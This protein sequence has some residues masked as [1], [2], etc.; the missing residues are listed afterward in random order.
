MKSYAKK[1]LPAYE[2]GE[3][4]KSVISSQVFTHLITTLSY[5]RAR[6][7]SEDLEQAQVFTHLITTLRPFNTYTPFLVG[8]PSNLR[9]F[10]SYH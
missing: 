10:M 2:N 3:E 6:S 1:C 9:P 5:A 4:A 7:R 8:L